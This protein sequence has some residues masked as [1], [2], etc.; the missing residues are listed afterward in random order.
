MSFRKLFPVTLAL[1]LTA[2]MAF[3]ATK[4]KADYKL[5]TLRTVTGTV[6]SVSMEA[7]IQYPGFA[8]DSNEGALTVHLGPYWYLV[9]ENF[10]VAAGDSVTA[11]VTSCPRTAVATDVTAFAVTVDTTGVS[12]LLRD[13]ATGLPLWMNGQ[14]GQGGGQGGGNGG[15][16]N[17]HRNGGGIYNSCTL[18]PATAV[19]IEGVVTDYAFGLGTH[20]NTLTVDAAGTLYS[21]GLGPYWFMVQN[22]F[23]VQVGD[24]VRAH[25]ALCSD[26]YA[27]FTVENV[28]T[29]A[30]LVLRDAD[31]VPLWID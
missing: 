10:A 8:L 14:G 21:F 17:G 11:R 27:A 25:I 1:L 7:G 12:I 13:E 31:G 5:S 30:T 2:T 16:R 4:K 20:S 19:D 18:D 6:T 22:G 29:G 9:S 3:G 23:T 15:P 26:H 24:Q 28:T